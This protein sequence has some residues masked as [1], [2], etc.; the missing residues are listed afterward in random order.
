MTLYEQ[1]II[2]QISISDLLT[3]IN[4][5]VFSMQ[6]EIR[7]NKKCSIIWHDL[8]KNPNDLPKKNEMIS[9]NISHCVMTQ[10]N[11]F[12]CYNFDDKKWYSNGL[13]INPPIAWCE[14]PKFED[15]NNEM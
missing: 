7:Q 15:M 4:A 12:A 8:R 11:K 5:K 1:D 3:H 10:K 2:N 6:E 14:I 13:I 9:A